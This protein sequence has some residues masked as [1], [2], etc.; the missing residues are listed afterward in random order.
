VLAA[1]V[2]CSG[3]RNAGVENR[4]CMLDEVDL[5]A[6]ARQQTTQLGHIRD[7][8]LRASLAIGRALG[9]DDRREHERSSARAQLAEIAR[10]REEGR[11]EGVGHALSL[12]SGRI[13]PLA[14]RARPHLAGRV[15]NVSEAAGQPAISTECVIVGAG[16]VGL[17]AVFEL[18][19]LGMKCQVVDSLAHP[20]GQCTELYPDKPIYDI[21]ALPV[22]GAQ[23]LI[24]RLMQQ[25]KPFHAGF[26]LGQEVTSVVRQSSGRFE[27]RPPRALASMPAALSSRAAS[28]RS[29][30]GACSCQKQ[31]A[32]KA[33]NSSI[34]CAVPRTSMAG[35]SWSRAAA[36]ARSTG[37]WNSAARRAR[38]RW[39]IEGRNFGPRPR[40]SRA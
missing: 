17:F 35:M 5:E 40:R 3:A 15:T 11:F 4:A 7:Q 39:C 21:P 1:H 10:E 27:V 2:V 29:S 37:R 38:S 12:S 23:E 18:G 28:A 20:G 26:H 31:S 33:I 9:R 32:T 16:P 24:D 34:A 6:A 36:T 30:R 19:L 14:A 22:C 8:H 13:P 25:I